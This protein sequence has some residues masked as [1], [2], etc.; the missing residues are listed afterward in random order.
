MRG[1][2]LVMLALADVASGD[3]GHA[4]AGQA[5]RKLLSIFINRIIRLAYKRVQLVDLISLSCNWAIWHNE[6]DQM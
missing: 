2:G 6:R 3:G 1:A 5:G 4:E